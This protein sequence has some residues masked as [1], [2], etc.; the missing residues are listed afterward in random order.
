MTG[1]TGKPRHHAPYHRVLPSTTANA[2]R[3]IVIHRDPTISSAEHDI[4]V[5]ALAH[6]HTE[7]ARALSGRLARP[8]IWEK[9]SGARNRFTVRSGRI[10]R[11]RLCPV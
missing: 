7:V 10:V 1:S 8:C 9:P 4:S 5:R 6:N 11:P 3:S 2:P